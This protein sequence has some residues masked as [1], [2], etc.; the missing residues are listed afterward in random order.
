MIDVTAPPYGATG[1]GVTDDAPAIQAALTAGGWVYIPAGTYRVATLPLRIYRNTRLTLDPGARIVR[2]ANIA[3]MVQNG[4]D[5]QSLGGYTGHGNILVEG[6]VWDVKGPSFAGS[7]GC[8]SFVHGENIT[9]RDVTILDVPGHHAIEANA[10]RGVRLEDLKIRGYCDPSGDRPVSEAIQ[11]DG[12]YEPGGWDRWGPYDNTNCQDVTVTGCSFGPSSTPGTFNWPR[13]VGSHGGTA[14]INNHQRIR[15]TGNTFDG[16]DTAVRAWHWDQA[17]IAGNHTLNCGITVQDSQNVMV[18]GNQIV[19]GPNTGIWL[20]EACNS[21]TVR[22]NDV[23][24]CD[25]YGIRAST[26]VVGLFITGNKVRRLGGTAV[27]GLSVTATCTGLMRYG[28]DLRS[29]GVTASLQDASPSPITS[30][31]DAL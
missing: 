25:G 13:G 31:A 27:Y 2:G 11:L 22:G 26:N 29:S 9:V 6:G 5:G 21:I 10:A 16:C 23:L 28:N 20:N 24:D 14:T 7:S 18:S 15:V 3:G 1:D 30:A 4:D 17:I 12:A 19:G 8:M